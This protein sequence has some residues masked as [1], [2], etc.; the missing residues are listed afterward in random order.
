MSLSVFWSSTTGCL[1]VSEV[2]IQPAGPGR[3]VVAGPLQFN[4][5]ARASKLIAEPL[6]REA[7]LVLDLHAVTRAD[8]AG[9]ALL[10]EWLRE[11]TRRQVEVRFEN[12]P[13]QL[14][15]I[16]RISRLERILP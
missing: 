16:A 5:V 13:P 12:I 15:A 8:S 3:Y 14:K 1:P 6:A 10:V 2:S 7:S 4:T 9:L 11:A